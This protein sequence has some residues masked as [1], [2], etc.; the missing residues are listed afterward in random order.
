MPA[1]QSLTS[2]A[3]HQAVEATVAQLRELPQVVDVLDPYQTGTVSRNGRI[4]YAVV[5]YPVAVANVKAAAV[6]AAARRP[7]KTG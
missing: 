4:A 1:G 2:P 3:G 5:A 6:T 7:G